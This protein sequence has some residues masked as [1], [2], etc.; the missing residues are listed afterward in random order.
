MFQNKNNQT[1]DASQANLS[2]EHDLPVKDL[3]VHT[4]KKDLEAIKHP[5]LAK[6]NEDQEETARIQPINREKLTEA[7]KGSPFLDFSAPKKSAPENTESRAE[8][9]KSDASDSRIQFVSPAP[10]PEKPAAA[11]HKSPAQTF[12]KPI[13]DSEKSSPTKQHPHHVNFGKVFAGVIAVLIV[14]IIAGGGYYF[15]LTRQSTPEIVVIPPVTEPEPTP[16]PV[17]KFSTDKPNELVVDT[18]AT[19]SLTLK[20]TLQ[21]Y[22]QDVANENIAS[23]VEFTTIDAEGNSILFKDFA[24]ISEITFSPALAANLSDTFSL[25]IYNDNAVTR[26]GLAIDSKDPVK[27]KSLM[28][29]EEK[30]LAEKLSPLFLATEYTL[31]AKIFATSDYNGLAIRYM[32]IISP[33]DLSV[34]Y[35]IYNDK[36]VIGT[37]KMTLRSITDYLKPQ[38][39]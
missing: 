5:E 2:Q 24:I 1:T 6:K 16:E 22:A 28:A 38:T 29:L 3:P 13:F 14:A 4:M 27:L 8:T 19:D 12:E 34:D 31:P 18:D 32:N 7:Q 33:E 21:N 36:L 30:T 17:S 39:E 23:P 37:T 26:L 15:W 11:D 25:F 20:E 10:K 9:I 35:A